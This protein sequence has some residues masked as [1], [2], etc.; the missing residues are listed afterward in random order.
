M[1]HQLLCA[2]KQQK[3]GHAL[4]KGAELEPES[5]TLHCFI[6]TTGSRR[7]CSASHKNTALPAIEARLNTKMYV[8]IQ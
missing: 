5:Y 2:L 3:N 8:P 1:W 4:V 6:H 7:P